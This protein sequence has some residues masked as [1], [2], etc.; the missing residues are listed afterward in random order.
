MKNEIDVSPKL[1]LLKL[2][3]LAIQMN[4]FTYTKTSG[5]QFYLIRRQ[6]LVIRPDQ[7]EIIICKNK[8][9][10]K[11]FENMSGVVPPMRK[12]E[13]NTALCLFTSLNTAQKENVLNFYSNMTEHPVTV[14]YGRAVAPF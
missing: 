9:I 5:T 12:Y 6:K 4:S 10:K 11:L 2:P 13:K 7:Q 8:D 1:N 3:E 14:P